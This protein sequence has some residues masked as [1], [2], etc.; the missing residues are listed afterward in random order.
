MEGSNDK[1]ATAEVGDDI[2]K[3]QSV[4]AERLRAGEARPG[5]ERD[6]ATKKAAA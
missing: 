6:E 1:P 5:S 3:E 2:G 4:N